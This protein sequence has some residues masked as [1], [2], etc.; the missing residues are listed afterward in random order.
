MSS[1]RLA[2]L[3]LCRSRRE[4]RLTMPGVGKKSFILIGAFA[5]AAAFLLG[6]MGWFAWLD[7]AYASGLGIILWASYSD[8][9]G[10]GKARKREYK[11]FVFVVVG[12]GVAIWIALKLASGGIPWSHPRAPR[13]TNAA[14]GLD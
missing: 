11:S 5:I 7:L 4:R 12:L 14:H 6:R 3:G 10:S 9:G 1:P 13:T 2:T 8:F